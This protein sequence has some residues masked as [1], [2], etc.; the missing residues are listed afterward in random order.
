MLIKRF[1]V[2]S[3]ILLVMQVASAINGMAYAADNTEGSKALDIQQIGVKNPATD[4]WRAI[5]QRSGDLSAKPQSNDLGAG[6]LINA[7]G[8]KWRNFRIS[9]LIPYSMYLLA[10]VLL[11][12]AL[13]FIILKKKKIPD[14]K[15]GRVVSR[16]SIMQRISH[17]LMVFLVGFMALTGLFLL[18]GRSI[19]IPLIG[20]EAFSVVASASKEGHNL[21]GLLVIASIL[22]M[23]VYFIRHNWPA[24][25]DLKW[26]VTVG[27]LFT[28]KHLKNDFF[29]AG[30]KILY[31]STIVLLLVLSITGLVLL[32]PYVQQSINLTTQL[33]L[34]IHAIAALL[35]ISFALAHIWMVFKVEGTLDAITGGDVDENWAKAHH[36][37][38][39]EEKVAKFELGDEKN[40]ASNLDNNFSKSEHKGVYE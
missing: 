21:F 1:V 28:K 35:L 38:W 11:V 4:L 30:E 7:N 27:G 36:S 9:K 6:T 17:W 2:F 31:W 40:N 24:R 19:I 12:L 20:T 15:S 10:G 29:N 34:I 18:F 25:G 22:L 26:I 23:L 39:Y 13:M 16:L 14:G 8:Q 32:Y 33:A 37:I 5:R 3:F